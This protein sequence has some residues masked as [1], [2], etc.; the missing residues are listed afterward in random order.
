MVYEEK[1]YQSVTRLQLVT[2]KFLSLRSITAEPRYY[3]LHVKYYIDL[4]NQ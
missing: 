3:F 1:Q 4:K 2:F